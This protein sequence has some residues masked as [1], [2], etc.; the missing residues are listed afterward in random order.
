[1]PPVNIASPPPVAGSHRPPGRTAAPGTTSRRPGSS[2]DRAQRR[3]RP[4]ARAVAALF[5]ILLAALNLFGT[6]YYLEPRAE[7]V[8]DPLHAWLKPSG[9]LGQGAGVLALTIF[10]FLWL[11][12]LRKRFRWLAFTGS[13]ANWLTTSS[14][15]PRVRGTKVSRGWSPMTMPAA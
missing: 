9:W 15:L 5:I 6:P 1:M 12:P 11:Y 10:L 8:R 3:A 14:A 7:Q 13:I 4:V 2:A